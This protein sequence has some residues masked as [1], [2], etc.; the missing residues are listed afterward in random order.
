MDNLTSSASVSPIS[1]SR[2][3]RSLRSAVG[4]EGSATA[5]H[6]K[7]EQTLSARKRASDLLGT[8]LAER[9]RLEARLSEFGRRD[10]MKAVTGR[11]ALENAI[12][13]T[14]EMIRTMDGLLELASRG[15]PVGKA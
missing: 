10:P 13:A 3:T 11:S 9:D 6:G 14:R 7:F 5:G 1:G 15:T 2:P 8:L 12:A 4:L